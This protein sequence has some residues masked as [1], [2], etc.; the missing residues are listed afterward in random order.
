M[1]YSKR[2]RVTGFPQCSVFSHGLAPKQLFVANEHRPTRAWKAEVRQQEELNHLVGVD[3][4]Q[5]WRQGEHRWWLRQF[6]K[7]C[8]RSS[9]VCRCEA[10]GKAGVDRFQKRVGMG[11]ASVPIPQPRKARRGS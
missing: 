9:Q 5:R 7:Q 2:N 1:N 3:E 10:F 6:L 4:R 11:G 8:P